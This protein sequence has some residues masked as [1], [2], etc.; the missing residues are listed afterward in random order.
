[1]RR[2]LFQ[3]GES[4]HIR[5]TGGVFSSAPLLARFRM[6]VELEDGNRVL[7][8]ESGAAEGALWEAYRIAGLKSRAG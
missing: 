8:P 2:Q 5:Y 7:T 4:V 3:A 6:L 1:V